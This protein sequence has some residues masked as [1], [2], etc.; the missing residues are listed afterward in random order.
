MKVKLLIALLEAYPP[1]STVVIGKNGFAVD[2]ESV[3]HDETKGQTS[4]VYLRRGKYYD[5]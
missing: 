5:G 4:P 2:V 3:F 1:Y